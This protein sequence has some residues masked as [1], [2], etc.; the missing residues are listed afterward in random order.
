MFRAAVTRDTTE[1]SAVGYIRY[2]DAE[3]ADERET[4]LRAAVRSEASEPARFDLDDGVDIE[5]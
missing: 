4:R 1:H 2:L 3:H 5:P